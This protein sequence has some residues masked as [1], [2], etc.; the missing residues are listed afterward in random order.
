MLICEIVD[1]D[2]QIL[3]IVTSIL[4]RAKAEGAQSVD[5]QQLINDLGDESM[6]PQMMVDILSRHTGEL[7]ELVGSA[8]VDAIQLNMGIK[9]KMMSKQDVD[10]AKMKNTALKQA[11]DSLK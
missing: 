11:L 5:M 7:K 3:D 10:A 9:K 2:R 8:T 6:T 4:L 1:S